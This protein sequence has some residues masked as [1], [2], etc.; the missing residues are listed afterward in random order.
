MQ[1]HNW[2]HRKWQKT[3]LTKE[4]PIIYNTFVFTDLLGALRDHKYLEYDPL[5]YCTLACVFKKQNE[6]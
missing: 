5:S 2:S 4:K 1:R 3:D 6:V